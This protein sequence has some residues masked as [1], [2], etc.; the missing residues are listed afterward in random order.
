MV[1]AIASSLAPAMTGTV[2]S[3]GSV[4]S[5]AVMRNSRSPLDAAL[6]AAAMFQTPAE[7]GA[8]AAHAGPDTRA[9]RTIKRW[10]DFMAASWPARPGAFRGA[11]YGGGALF[12][13]DLDVDV[14]HVGIHQL[15]REIRLAILLLD[16]DVLAVV[17]LDGVALRAELRGE[18]VTHVAR[19]VVLGTAAADVGDHVDRFTLARRDAELQVT[20]RQRLAVE[21]DAPLVGSGRGVGGGECGQHQRCGDGG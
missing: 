18:R 13:L 9:A 14:A 15:E 21:L 6:P 19:H 4:P 8:V 7:G 5:T 11:L 12:A 1:R 16:Q 17:D 20:R 3:T 10:A 2:I